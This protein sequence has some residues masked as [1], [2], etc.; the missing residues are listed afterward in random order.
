MPAKGS[1]IIE[2][3]STERNELLNNTDI[4]MRDFDSIDSDDFLE[5]DDNELC[6]TGKCACIR[7]R[8]CIEKLFFVM[9]IIAFFVILGLILKSTSKDDQTESNNNCPTKGCVDVASNLLSSMDQQVKPCVDFYKYACGGWE[10]HTPIPPGFSYWDRTQE[11][12]YNNMYQLHRLLETHHGK[13]DAITKA[14]LF[15]DSCMN[16]ESVD[17]AAIIQKFQ[18]IIQLATGTENNFTLVV[19]LEKIHRLKSWPLFTVSVGPDE[20]EGDNNIIKISHADMPYPIHVLIEHEQPSPSNRS[21]TKYLEWDAKQV[22]KRYLGDMSKTLKMFWNKTEE[23]AKEI[24][25]NLLTLDIEIAKIKHNDGYIFNRAGSYNKTTV[26]SL[27]QKCG[28]LEWESYLTG[29]TYDMAEIKNTDTV[30]ILHEDTLHK[31]CDVIKLYESSKEN[32]T[33][34]YYY[35]LVH[36]VRSFMPYFEVSNFADLSEQTEFEFDGELWQRCTFYT[37]R[38]FGFATAAMYINKTSQ[39]ENMAQIEQLVQDVKDAFKEYVLRKVWF[40][41]DIRQK[42]SKKIDEMLEKVNYPSYILKQT[43]LE[44]F[45]KQFDVGNDWFTNLLN[46]KKFDVSSMFTEL[47]KQ[48][49]KKSWIRPPFTVESDYDPVR[50]ELNF[51]TAMLHLPFYTADGPQTF[52]YGALAAVI[53][54]EITHAFDIVGRQYNDKGKLEEWWDPLTV[55]SFNKTANCMIDQYDSYNVDGISINGRQTLD[56]NIA[57]NGGLRAAYFA[58]QLWER[59]GIKAKELPVAELSNRQLFFI[60][61]AQMFC[62]KWKPDGLQKHIIEDKHSPGPIRVRG[63]ISNMNTFGDAF[64]CPWISNYNPNSKCE[65]W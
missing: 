60:S 19:V 7:Q 47:G 4:K 46:W 64:K 33:V 48:T 40:R 21:T 11:L 29:L 42:A 34:L 22:R 43:F 15:H 44:K 9:L 36:A 6:T 31:L 53:G 58:Y 16:E 35:L 41:G 51:P 30:A 14:K 26:S 17:K 50:N 10:K 32:R 3:Q 5:D 63:A 27:Q 65:V 57:D 52:N 54:H 39:H 8:S 12:A 2:M 25:E 24:S 45:Y 62:S 37:N 1:E 49:D 28:M 13:D 23:D 59:K 38:A 56:E 61:Y 55:S 18:N 20:Q